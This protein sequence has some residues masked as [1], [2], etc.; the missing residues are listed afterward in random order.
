MNN[1]NIFTT[2]LFFAILFT[3]F[4]Q[5]ASYRKLIQEGNFLQLE[6]EYGQA[7][8]VYKKAYAIDSSSANINYNLGFCYLKSQSQKKKAEYYLAKAVSN[9]TRNY[10][11][12][13]FEKKA[14]IVAYF[15]YG[16]AKH[17]NYKFDEAT[18]QY[19]KYQSFLKSG[20]KKERA[21]VDRYIQI[22]KNAKE[23]VAAPI[24]VEVTNLGPKVNSEY[25]EFSPV[26]SADERT[27]IYTARRK[28]STGGEKAPDGMYFEDILIAYKNNDNTWSEPTGIGPFINTFGHEGSV[29]LTPDGQRLLLYR[30]DNGDGNLYFSDWDG[31]DW[32]TPQKFG[33]NINTEFWETSAC[34]SP[35]GTTLFFVSDRKGGYGGRDIYFCKK[36]P[37]GNWGLAQNLGP[38]I[39]TPY[40]DEAPYVH[41]DGVTMFFASKG[42]KNM[43]NFDVFFSILGDDGK[44]SDPINS[45][46]PINT[47]DDDVFY[48]TS[49][50]GKRGYYSSSTDAGDKGYGEKD[51]FMINIPEVKEKCLVLF[52]GKIVP[53]EGDSMPEDILIYV[54]NK[55]TG[56]LVGTY[57]P[58]SAS[59]TFTMILPPKTDCEFQY[60]SKGNEFYKEDVYISEDQCYQEIEKE[61]LLDKTTIVGAKPKVRPPVSTFK[62]NA[63]VYNKKNNKAVSDAYIVFRNLNDSTRIDTINSDLSGKGNL[64]VAPCQ[65]YLVTTYKDG[66][67][68]N[69]DTILTSCNKR[70]T[71]DLIKIGLSRDAALAN[72]AEMIMV[73]IIDKKSKAP[74]ED[75]VLSFKNKESNIDNSEV[76]DVDG[77]AYYVFKSRN[78]LMINASKDGYKSSSKEVNLKTVKAGQTVTIALD[79]DAKPIEIV[80][81]E[82]ENPPV[83]SSTEDF[84]SADAYKC[85][86]A[87]NKKEIDLADATF[88]EFV[89]KLAEDLKGG[90]SVTVKVNGSAS[91]VPTRTFGTNEKLCKS[92]A[93]SG[94]DK[95]VEALKTKGADVSKLK[96]AKIDGKVNGP[97]YKGDYDINKEEYQKHQYVEINRN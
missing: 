36:L 76:T 6:E 84:V 55:E 30:D 91:T 42:H 63:F 7:L 74:I 38:T 78:N 57:R 19:T 9:V 39:N 20:D 71:E 15:Y 3:A 49:P 25:P 67:S 21:E 73:K 61:I 89:N 69:R 2:I 97:A 96:F 41:P 44:F 11:D 35:D 54:N 5:K 18:E 14:P 56:D 53:A 75:A 8:E 13:L 29:G 77:V 62:L 72:G 33:S 16:Q 95:L 94:K 40:D 65:K 10:S 70:A 37:N 83:K 64:L 90:K 48:V 68:T 86:F 85:F 24:N 1:K 4:G 92:R 26:I 12:D 31:K 32:S 46:Y 66:F 82:K 58:K 47:P 34:L 80:T 22:S 79:R 17:I 51:I 59:G 60:T 27:I 81:G 50:D 45:G 52:K 88:N 23:F 93:N 28:S 43:G 87:Y